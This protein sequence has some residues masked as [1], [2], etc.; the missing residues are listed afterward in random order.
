MTY[1]KHENGYGQEPIIQSSNLKPMNSPR[2]P[3]EKNST[4]AKQTRPSHNSNDGRNRRLKSARLEISAEAS[5]FGVPSA[6]GYSDHHVTMN[7]PYPRRSSMTAK[8]HTDSNASTRRSK[9]DSHYDS[10]PKS[11]DFYSTMSKK[12]MQSSSTETTTPKGNFALLP[13][14]KSR[15]VEIFDVEALQDI[16]KVEYESRSNA[17][18]VTP[19]L[20]GE[21]FTAGYS[22]L[23]ST[24]AS[25][26]VISQP[27]SASSEADSVQALPRGK[28]GNDNLD[29]PLRLVDNAMRSLRVTHRSQ[30]DN[31][32]NNY[33]EPLS[34]LDAVTPKGSSKLLESYHTTRAHE[35]HDNQPPTLRHTSKITPRQ[36][37]SLENSPSYLTTDSTPR[38]HTIS[39]NSRPSAVT[40]AQSSHSNFV[41]ISTKLTDAE[42]VERGIS[43]HEANQLP[44]ATYHFK[45]A[46]SNGH[47]TGILL[48]SLSLRHGWGCAANPPA[49]VAWLRK[50]ADLESDVTLPAAATASSS[51]STD[52]ASPESKEMR[53][54]LGMA[55]YEL[56][57]SYLRGWGVER[58]R[59]MAL[60]CFEISAGFGDTDGACEAA[61]MWANSIGTARNAKKKDKMTKAACY[62]RQA[63]KS[64][65]PLVGVSWIWKSKFDPS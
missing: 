21:E 16:P 61:Y 57:Q 45:Q 49:A 34:P 13:T 8:Q 40:T 42:H 47:R 20:R 46:A 5:L 32:N 6:P 10:Y 62:Y 59:A 3:T 55:L 1:V 37:A 54:Q 27:S 63:S 14:G 24:P 15:F 9:E 4:A 56:G 18:Y 22:P 41:G 60:K 17:R 33:N 53:A 52:P 30:H 23:Q 11:A 12:V 31:D 38:Q 25:R 2:S 58:D 65:V 48:Y 29:S 64:G 39:L 26:S 50:A 35:K 7:G 43:C 28:R 44:Q 19:T 51:S 36:N